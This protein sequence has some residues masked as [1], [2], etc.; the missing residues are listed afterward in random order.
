MLHD[1]GTVVMWSDSVEAAQAP[2]RTERSSLTEGRRSAFRPSL[3]HGTGFTL[4]HAGQLRE[5][6]V[7]CSFFF[8]DRPESTHSDDWLG[9]NERHVQHPALAGNRFTSYHE[10]H[11]Q[12]REQPVGA[13]SAIFG[14]TLYAT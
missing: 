8:A 4:T 2:L 1:P 6:P 11:A 12:R 10:M 13:H 7:G 14:G 3:H 5:R 9:P